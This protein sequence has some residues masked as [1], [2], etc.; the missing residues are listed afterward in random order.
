MK[1]YRFKCIMEN[2]DKDINGYRNALQEEHATLL[3]KFRKL[4]KK[5]KNSKPEGEEFVLKRMQLKAMSD[6]LD[7]LL[8]RMALVDLYFSEDDDSYFVKSAKIVQYEDE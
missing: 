1:E 6:Y 2:K 8:A 3:V 4:N 7:A 5:T